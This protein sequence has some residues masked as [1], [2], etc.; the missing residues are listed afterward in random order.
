MEVYFLATGDEKY[1][2]KLGFF[3]LT[4]QVL[5]SIPLMLFY[6]VPGAAHGI[7]SGELAIW[8]PLRFRMKKRIETES[9]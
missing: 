1:A 9:Q 2:T 6:G 5:A 8:L 4:I 7:L 3:G